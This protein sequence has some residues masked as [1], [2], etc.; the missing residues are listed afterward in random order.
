M[1]AVQKTTYKPPPSAY[2]ITHRAMPYLCKM[3]DDRSAMCIF[4]KKKHARVV[5][6]VFESYYMTHNE[7][8]QVNNIM[9]MYSQIVDPS[10]LEIVEM[11]A[12]T[13]SYTCVKYNIDACVV[14]DISTTSK[15]LVVHYEYV[16]SDPPVEMSI[17]MLNDLWY[18]K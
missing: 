14:H 16:K 4:E 12:S 11:D 9:D 15:K 6:G 10:L 7:W 5:A 17:E 2:I 1:I 18:Q 3:R 13:L 8:P